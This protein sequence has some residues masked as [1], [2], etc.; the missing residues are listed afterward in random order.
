MSKKD[1]KYIF[2]FIFL[3]IFIH[4]IAISVLLLSGCTEN[5]VREEYKGENEP[6]VYMTAVDNGIIDS[7]TR[8]WILKDKR[9]KTEYL[10]IRSGNSEGDVSVTP[11]YNADGSLYKE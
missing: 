10:I 4:I 9:T 2:K 7:Y 8:Y 1:L 11:L 5:T 6:P 3:E